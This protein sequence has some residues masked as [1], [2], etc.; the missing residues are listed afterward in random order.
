MTMSE[1]NPKRAPGH[2][3]PTRPVDS[4]FVLD[5]YLYYNIN[6]ASNQYGELMERAFGALDIDQ[7]AWRVLSLLNHDEHSRVSDIARRGM[8]KMPTLSRRI[9][10]MVTDGLI[11]REVG[12][13]DRR[14][15]RVSLTAKGR[16]ELR[17][18]KAA[19]TAIFDDA[20]TGIA[21]EEIAIAI[22]VLQRMRRNLDRAD[23]R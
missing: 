12:T 21:T 23:E 10:R 4:D 9:D 19:S 3:A 6:R 22:T 11:L 20:T 5:D 8:I 14:T 17:R 15:V 2:V 18:A 13:D 16:E 7:T 1:R